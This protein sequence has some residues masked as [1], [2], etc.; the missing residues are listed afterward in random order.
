MTNPLLDP[1]ARL[2]VA[3]RGNRVHAP[4]NTFEALRQAVA[5][6]A[7]AVEFDIRVTRD[8]IPVLFHDPDL[9]RTT[10]GRGPLAAL[11]FAETRALNAAAG[12]ASG[13]SQPIPS[14]EEVLDALRIP[15]V[16]EVK[17]L[18]AVEGTE[19][20]IRRFGAQERVIVGS[21]EADVMARF[22][23]SGLA[24]CASML[25]AI[26]FIPFALLGIAPAKPRYN[27]LSLT[28]R[29]RGMPIPVRRL[30]AA[31]RRI[32]IPTQVWTVN[33]PDVAASLWASGVSAI[34]TD[35]PSTLVRVRP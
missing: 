7:D 26:R 33:D 8:G 21:A 10:N 3:H 17:E 35:D 13:G 29:F 15:M 6:G 24:T 23:R 18:A 19:R 34:V 25:D 27:V 14:L 31:A 22:Y 12:H 32:G 2:V 28:P 20:L 16:I 1:T 30:A 4:E 9:D 11:S 5:L